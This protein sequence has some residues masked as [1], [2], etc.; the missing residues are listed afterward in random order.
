MSAV[1]DDSGRAEAFVGPFAVGVVLSLVTVALATFL[2]P[3]H[4]AHRV[5]RHDGDRGEDPAQ[6][7][8]PE[9]ESETAA[10]RP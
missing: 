5:E 6:A 3:D 4:D 1:Y 7:P 2:V 10:T 8:E 9:S